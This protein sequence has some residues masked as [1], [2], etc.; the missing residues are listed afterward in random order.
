M[1]FSRLSTDEIRDMFE[2]AFEAQVAFERDISSFDIECERG[3]GDESL[4]V[5]V[6]I[7]GFAGAPTVDDFRNGKVPEADVVTMERG[8]VGGLQMVLDKKDIVFLSGNDYQLVY[9]PVL[10]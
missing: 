3:I 2:L 10:S 9:K 8:D 7:S 5:L 6:D 1:N 4:K